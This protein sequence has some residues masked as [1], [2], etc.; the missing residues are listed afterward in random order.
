M[1][2]RMHK[3]IGKVLLSDREIV[4]EYFRLIKNKDVNRL[5]DLFVDDAIIYEPSS[6]IQGGLRGKGVIKPFLEIVLMANDGLQNKIEFEEQQQQKQQQSTDNNVIALV[7]FE[8]VER[9]QARFEFELAKSEV[10]EKENYGLHRLKKIQSLYIQ[11][12]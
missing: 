10:K 12:I 3:Q 6:N 5:L 8:R 11:F 7:T 4:Y 1:T 9:L 2:N